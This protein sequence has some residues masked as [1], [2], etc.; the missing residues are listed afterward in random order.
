MLAIQCISTRALRSQA[1]EHSEA[2]E[3]HYALSGVDYSSYASVA[4]GVARLELD[5]DGAYQYRIVEVASVADSYLDLR[6]ENEDALEALSAWADAGCPRTGELIEGLR[7]AAV[8][9]ANAAPVTVARKEQ[10]A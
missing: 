9:C 7:R 6:A 2:W 5:A 3:T 8:A 4:A 10:A 1:S